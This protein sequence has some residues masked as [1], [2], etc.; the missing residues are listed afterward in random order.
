MKRIALTLS[1][2]LTITIYFDYSA[3]PAPDAL[4]VQRYACFIKDNSQ[5]YDGDT[6]RDVMILAAE[7]NLEHAS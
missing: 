5:V 7:V 6:F 1:L 2:L 3:R 4:P